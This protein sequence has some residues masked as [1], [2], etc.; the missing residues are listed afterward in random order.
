MEQSCKVQNKTT[1][2]GKKLTE[3]FLSNKELVI[4]SP[5]IKKYKS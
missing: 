3:P 2:K 1:L 4:L 5:K